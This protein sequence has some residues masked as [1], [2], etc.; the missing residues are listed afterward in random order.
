MISFSLAMLRRQMIVIG[1]VVGL[2]CRNSVCLPGQS[3]CHTINN[4]GFKIMQ[5]I[6]ML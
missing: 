3:T 5:M 2:V 1:F 6:S 4:T